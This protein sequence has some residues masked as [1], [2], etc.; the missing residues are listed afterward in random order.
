MTEAELYF[1]YE[2][3]I[4]EYFGRNSSLTTL[5]PISEALLETV[6]LQRFML[7]A[8]QTSL[9]SINDLANAIGYMTNLTHLYL[10]LK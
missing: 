2:S 8:S 4:I 9:G 7:V 3:L 10:D 6:K 1:Q 5:K